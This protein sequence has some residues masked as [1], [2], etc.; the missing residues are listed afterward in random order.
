M[1]KIVKILGLIFVLSLGL[2]GGCATVGDGSSDGTSGDETLSPYELTVDDIACVGGGRVEKVTDDEYQ[3]GTDEN[4]WSLKYDKNGSSTMFKFQ[5]SNQI[6]WEKV[7]EFSFWVYNPNIEYDYTFQVGLSKTDAASFG[8]SQY[9]GKKTRA[10]Y[11]W[12]H[13]SFSN[14]DIVAATKTGH[15]YLTFSFFHY[16]NGGYLDLNEDGKKETPSEQWLQ[17]ELYFDDFRIIYA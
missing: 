1:K 15:Q 9:I 4:G 13:V 17:L 6:D 14:S 8:D 10:T 5:K 12:T 2:W 3:H 7:Q 11:E 16:D